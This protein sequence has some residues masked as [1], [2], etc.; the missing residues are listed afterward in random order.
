[1]RTHERILETGGGGR[2]ERGRDYLTEIPRDSDAVGVRT[3]RLSATRSRVL[4]IFDPRCTGA[5][6][7]AHPYRRE[8]SESVGGGREEGRKGGRVDFVSQAGRL[9]DRKA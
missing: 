1:M 2:G 4:V 5:S 6:I 3:R 7:N 8:G 9:N